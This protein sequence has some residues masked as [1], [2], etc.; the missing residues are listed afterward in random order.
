MRDLAYQL[1]SPGRVNVVDDE[2]QAVLS[3]LYVDP[4]AI[5]DLDAFQDVQRDRSITSSDR[6]E[7]SDT[8]SDDDDDG[9]VSIKPDGPKTGCVA[10][11]YN[12]IL[13][14]QTQAGKSTFLQGIKRYVNPRCAI[15]EEAIGNGDS[16]H[17]QEVHEVTLETRFPQYY[18]VNTTSMQEVDIDELRRDCT[19][20]RYKRRLDRTRDRA[21][22][23]DSTSLGVNSTIHIF[24][25]P[26][27]DDTNGNN[28]RNVAKILTALL[29]AKATEVH[30]M[31]LVLNRYAPL[32]E[33]L[34]DALQTYHNIFSAMNGLWAVVHTKAKDYDRIVPDKILKS[35][36][37]ERT[38]KLEDI[39]QQKDIPY[40]VID[41]DFQE[42]RPLHVYFRQ[43]TIRKILRLASL[44]QPIPLN[45]IQLCKTPKMIDIDKIILQ[46][47]DEQLRIINIRQS[48]LQSAIAMSDQSILEALYRIRE[49]SLELS[50]LDTDV[51]ELLHQV[52]FDRNW[53]IWDLVT[54]RQEVIFTCPEI[55]H[56]IDFLQTDTSGVDVKECEGGIGSM[57]WSVKV[58]SL[59]LH[60]GYYRAK[61]Y[62]KRCNKNKLQIA[63]KKAQLREWEATLKD[64]QLLRR[65]LLFGSPSENISAAGLLKEQSHCMD[66]KAR[67]ERKSLHL[68]LF[69]AMAMEGVFE[70]SSVDCVRKLELFYQTYVPM[71]GEEIPLP[72]YP[73]QQFVP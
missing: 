44:N 38:K 67:A 25:T 22:R 11:V 36:L 48:R 14:G 23:Q 46:R 35:Y 72:P 21:V 63:E 62:V 33:G 18:V 54:R 10:P 37:K 27:L 26:G 4:D 30:L 68:N 52:S 59:R 19:E 3:D 57:N 31:L 58:T 65:E 66:M 17:T 7:R 49:L 13:L 47:Y 20:S 42:R 8:S 61:L 71:E 45:R 50:D 12:I 64:R 55:D 60:S 51:P 28:E 73:P 29:E 53:R 69:K 32:T 6:S 34:R 15:D 1:R 2:Y 5:N 40:H 41:C 56:P 9:D 16:S 70:G 43:Q 24:D 39:M